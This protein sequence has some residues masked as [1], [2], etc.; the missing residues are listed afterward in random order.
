MSLC[1]DSFA[2]SAFPASDSTST[3][4]NAAANFSLNFRFLSSLKFSTLS[5]LLLLV[6][7][8]VVVC[9]LL[10]VVVGVRISSSISSGLASGMPP[11]LFMM[12]TARCMAVCLVGGSMEKNEGVAVEEG[13]R[14]VGGG[15]RCVCF[16]TDGVLLLRVLLLLLLL[17]VLVLALLLLLLLWVLGMV[18]ICGV[19]S[20]VSIVLDGLGVLF[21]VDGG[22]N[23]GVVYLRVGCF[24]V[25]V[26]IVVARVGFVAGGVVDFR[27]ASV[28]IVTVVVGAVNFKAVDADFAVAVVVGIADFVVSGVGVVAEVVVSGVDILVVV[29][30]VA[31]VVVVV[32]FSNASSA[33]APADF[34]TWARFSVF[35]VG[36][37]EGRIFDSG[38]KSEKKSKSATNAKVIY[39]QGIIHTSR[40]DTRANTQTHRGIHAKIRIRQTCTHTHTYTRT[41]HAH[42][43]HAHY[44][45]ILS[46][47]YTCTH[48]R[49]FA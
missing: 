6:L 9:L 17:L 22:V 26:A 37:A 16:S 12:S 40:T 30:A 35:T 10:V 25:D 4:P 18:P 48:G 23:F 49:T 7:L 47:T 8:L 3:V 36:M 20:V 21:M 24:A 44:T 2:S 41:H 46:H 33:F 29:V 31:V 45:R 27:S 39:N 43:T 11:L 28:F 34:L 38:L 32:D 19:F 13:V 15:V 42:T 5:Y 1:A 14:C